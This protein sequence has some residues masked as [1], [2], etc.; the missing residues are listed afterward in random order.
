MLEKLT[1]D[2][3]KDVLHY[4]YIAA[5]QNSKR[6]DLFISLQYKSIFLGV[7]LKVVLA[8]KDILAFS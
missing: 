8:F 6:K 4:K 7:A 2:V 5:V 3:F 1:R